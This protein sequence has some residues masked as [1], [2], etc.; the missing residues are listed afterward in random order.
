MLL[1]VGPEVRPISELLGEGTAAIDEEKPVGLGDEPSPRVG[2][3]PVSHAASRPRIPGRRVAN[4]IAAGCVGVGDSTGRR[5]EVLEIGE[6]HDDHVMPLL[7]CRSGGGPYDDDAF[8]SGWRLGELAAHLGQPGISAMADSIRPEER[9]Q[10]DLIAMAHGFT[11]SVEPSRDAEWL[12]VTFV[13][14]RAAA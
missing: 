1:D 8:R 7:L 2:E 9:H 13:R 5:C 12:S 14:S 6:E 10:A 3:Y 4:R 11:M